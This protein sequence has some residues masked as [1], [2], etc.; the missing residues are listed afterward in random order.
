MQPVKRMVHIVDD[1]V[2]LRRSLQY[3]LR[4]AGYGASTYD[5]PLA[6]IEAAAKL[7]GGCVLLDLH[8][9]GMDG[10]ELHRRLVA[11]DVRAPVILMTTQCD[12]PTAVN[13][14]K[15]GVVDFIEK[16]FNDRRVLEAIE[17]AFSANLYANA[18]REGVRAA[19]RIAALTPRE[20][21]VLDGLAA[22]HANKTIAYDLGISVR[23]VEVHRARLLDRLGTRR[24]AVAIR[25]SVLASLG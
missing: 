15:S 20:R 16:P 4:A 18:A 12:V 6:V 11:L 21:Q 13:A 22:G 9:P 1:D 17:S 7:A 3:L 5:S 24:L 25:M 2:S 14:L 19:R 10:L 23:T 8:M